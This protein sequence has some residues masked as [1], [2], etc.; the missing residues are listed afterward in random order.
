[1]HAR[2]IFR[3]RG[4]LPMAR[5]HSSVAPPPTRGPTLQLRF[6]KL[7]DKTGGFQ[8]ARLERY[9]QVRSLGLGFG[10]SGLGFRVWGL[11]FRV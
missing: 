3:L 7:M 11:G 8:N 9:V 6:G 10:V 5:W 4:L 1:M 2:F